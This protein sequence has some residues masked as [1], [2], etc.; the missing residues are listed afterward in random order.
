MTQD[1]TKL[2][3]PQLL[4]ALGDDAQKWAEAFKQHADAARSN[5]DDPYDVGWMTSWFA[6]AI[7]H[8]NRVRER[9][10]DEDLKMVRAAA[11]LICQAHTRDDAQVG[12]VVES[13]PSPIITGTYRSD[14]LGAWGYL[15]AFAGRGPLPEPTPICARCSS[16]DHHVSDCDR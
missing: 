8:S 4:E 10:H 14:Y 9:S 15:R 11:R 2:T 12:Y 3:E 1:Y 7:E 16:P 13:L 6:N 5:F